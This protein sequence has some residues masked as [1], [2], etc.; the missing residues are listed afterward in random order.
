MAEK[1]QIPL[2]SHFLLL[3]HLSIFLMWK[4]EE[5]VTLYA[6]HKDGRTPNE[7]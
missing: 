6:E 2:S 4:L 3:F 1:K 7:K 5:C